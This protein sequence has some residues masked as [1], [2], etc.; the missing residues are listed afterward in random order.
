VSQMLEGETLREKVGGNEWKWNGMGR[1]TNSLNH[2][3]ST[4][5]V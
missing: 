2:T 5:D 4:I 1:E 3:I